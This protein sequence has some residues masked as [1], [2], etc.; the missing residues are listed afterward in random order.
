MTSLTNLKISTRFGILLAVLI[1]GITVAGFAAARLA[2]RE[3]IS[4]KVEEL[5]AIVDTSIGIADSLNKQIQAGKITK[6]QAIEALRERLLPMTFDHGEGYVFVITMDGIAVAM[7]DS[8]LIGTNRLNART[9]S[10]ELMV[11]MQRDGVLNNNGTF[12]MTYLYPKPGQTA[13]VEKLAYSVE[14]KPWNMFFGT[15]VYLDS[16]ETQFSGILWSYVALFAAVILVVAAA[17]TLIALSIV[18]PLARLQASMQR[19]AQGDKSTAI[20]GV[21][22]GGGGEIG[23]MAAAVQVFKETMIKADLL[24]AEQEQAKTA[25]AAAE[26]AAMNRT[27]DG[28][29]AKVGDLVAA[30]SAGATDLE[31]TAQTMSS[32]ATRA[33]S[34]A[35]AVAAAAEQ[36]SAGAQTVA[37]AAEELTASINEIGR[38]VAQ[39]SKIAGQAVANAQR[40]DSIV[41]ALADGADKIGHVVGLITNIAGQTNLLALN[42]TIEAARAGDAGKGFAVVATE[43]KSLA[44]QTAKATEEIGT[45]IAQI[46]SATKEAVD[47]IR[48]IAGTIE[49]VSSISMSIAAA[50]DEQGA[51]TAEIARNVQQTAQSAQDVTTNIDGV[52]QAAT[53]T[54]AAA[55]RVLSAA[56]AL[57]RQASQLTNEVSGFIAGV[58]AA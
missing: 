5:K 29:E 20:A 13:E 52:N 31:A 56:G 49:E 11:R 24:A 50:V 45:Q 21:G 55:T 43:V 57:S 32:T 39:S 42:A 40:T 36:A 6:E 48:G 18:R 9:T 38:Q 23:R 2:H 25:A 12:V 30:L 27:A 35:S 58:R 16:L 8:K 54:G 26:K 1:L 10:G 3:L 41:R 22:R 7:P 34:Q 19:L 33:N 44:N 37:A 17:A 15:G 53:D 28:F 4:S 51:A 14:Y 46:Q 47:A